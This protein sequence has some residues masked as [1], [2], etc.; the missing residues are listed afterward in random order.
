MPPPQKRGRGR[1]PR[2][3]STKPPLQNG[4]MGYDPLKKF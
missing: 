1:H 4:P 2:P 3:V